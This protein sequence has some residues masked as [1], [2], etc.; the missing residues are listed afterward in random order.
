MSPQDALTGTAAF[1]AQHAGHYGDGDSAKAPFLV[2]GAVLIAQQAVSLSLLAAK[3]TIPS[4]TGATGLILRA[5]NPKHLPTPY[6]LPF[7]RDA[8]QAFGHLVLKRNA[9]MHPRGHAWII[10]DVDLAAGLRVVCRILDHLLITQPLHS[11]L[12]TEI[13]L[14]AIEGALADIL[15]LV[16]FLE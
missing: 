14:P 10:A 13:Q 2:L 7:D 4:Q 6:T 12:L 15:A 16:E 1:T 3:D 11:G 5:A 9:F 8:R